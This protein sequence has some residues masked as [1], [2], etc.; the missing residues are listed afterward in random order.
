MKL[1][2]FV[3]ILVFSALALSEAAPKVSKNP[4]RL[5]A[6]ADFPEK[7]TNKLTKGYVFFTS[8]TGGE[9][10]VHI[11]FTGLPKVG[12]PFSYHIHENRVDADTC[13]DAGG[14]FD[15]HRGL[16]QCP[17]QGDDAA[18]QVGDLSGKH[19]WINTTCYQTEYTDPYLS[20]NLKDPAYVVGKSLVLHL[21][22]QSRFAC[23]NINVATKEQYK[24]MFGLD[25]IDDVEERPSPTLTEPEA[26]MKPIGQ[27][28][29]QSESIKALDGDSRNSP[30][31]SVTTV[32]SA[33]RMKADTSMLRL[34]ETAVSLPSGAHTVW[35]ALIWATVSTIV[36]LFA[37]M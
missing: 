30:I 14:H 36:A 11:D 13:E 28:S 17:E 26:A 4:K 29:K 7:G 22:D 2:N 5:V 31:K 35:P 16:P 18:C 1:P 24:Q 6:V 15:P 23:A 33:P 21:A 32:T 27:I 20:L 8:P 3:L 25:P 37:H 19:G 10:K 9:V 12:G 34:N